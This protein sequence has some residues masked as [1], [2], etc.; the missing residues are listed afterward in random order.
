[1]MTKTLLAGLVGLAVAGCTNPPTPTVTSASGSSTSTAGATA[2]AT[3]AATSTRVAEYRLEVYLAGKKVGD[4]SFSDLTA[5]PQ[6]GMPGVPGEQGPT[7]LSVLARAQVQDFTSV[8]VSGFARGR[9]GPASLTLTKAEVKDTV[10]IGLTQQGT[11]KLA[12]AEMPKERWIIDVQRI[13]VQG[14]VATSAPTGSIEV[15]VA[16]ARKAALTIQDLEKLPTATFGA[17]EGPTLPS[18]LKLAGVGAFTRVKLVGLNIGRQG[19][20]EVTLTSDK[21]TDRVILDF[22]RQGTVKLSSQDVPRAQWIL[23]ISRIEVD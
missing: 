20:A 18:V 14:N 15:L 13:D 11:A 1:M 8:Q 22:T 9:T 23:D 21:V 3:P 10:I 17:D 2:S 19:P 5:L 7:L 6:K 4:L 16:G 12:S